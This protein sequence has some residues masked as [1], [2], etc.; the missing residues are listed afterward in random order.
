MLAVSSV[1]F[2]RTQL[3]AEFDCGTCTLFP[4][5]HP[6]PRFVRRRIWR[7]RWYNDAGRGDGSVRALAVFPASSYR[8]S[9]MTMGLGI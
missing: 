5:C 9:K 8:S 2:I 4:D 3:F 7:F 1:A 6:E